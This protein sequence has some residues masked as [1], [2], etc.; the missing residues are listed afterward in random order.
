MTSRLGKTARERETG[1]A[2]VEFAVVGLFAIV[3]LFGLILFALHASYSGLAE[4][5]ARKAARAAAARSLTTN[6]YPGDSEVEAAAAVPDSILR[7]PTA[8][9]V[10]RRAGPGTSAAPCGVNPG[11]PRPCDGGDVVTVTVTYGVPGLSAAAAV[12]PGLN[13]VGLDE[14]TRQAS[15]R[16]E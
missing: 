8:I 2:A 6:R 14:V 7:D 15:A 4:H 12:I 1:A 9:V 13:S 10:D 3:L 11:A 5:G 16:M